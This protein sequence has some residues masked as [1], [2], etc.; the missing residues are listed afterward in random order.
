MKFIILRIAFILLNFAI[1]FPSPEKST[2]K[3]VEL[4]TAE[5]EAVRTVWQAAQSASSSSP[6][7]TLLSHG[8]MQNVDT[9]SDGS[10]TDVDVHLHPR[11]V[12]PF[13]FIVC[14]NWCL[15]SVTDLL[16]DTGCC[17]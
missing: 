11:A 5:M 8:S 10:D 2:E 16:V 15:S 12:W 14:G 1:F 7:G 6:D 13:N 3:L 9:P 17:C 4:S